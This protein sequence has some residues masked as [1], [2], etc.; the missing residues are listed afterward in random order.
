ML[1]RKLRSLQSNNKHETIDSFPSQTISRRR[2]PTLDKT[3]IVYQEALETIKGE[4][5]C[6][7]EKK[8]INPDQL[9][10]TDLKPRY[11]KLRSR[12]HGLVCCADDLCS[13]LLEQAYRE[14][15]ST[16]EKQVRHIQT[17]ITNIT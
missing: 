13:I 3:K 11:N 12:Q 9:N 2:K 1:D 14:D 16:I 17:Q 7:Q 6:F 4:L 15:P 5:Y 10:H 8:E